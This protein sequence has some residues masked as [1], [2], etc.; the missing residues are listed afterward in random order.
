MLN[1]NQF[2]QFTQS[3]D[4]EANDKTKKKKKH[5][6]NGFSNEIIEITAY[7]LNGFQL[8]IHQLSNWEKRLWIFNDLI[9]NSSIRTKFIYV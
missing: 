1:K 9:Q 6:E 8:V 3:L 2:L 5:L 7:F 4:S